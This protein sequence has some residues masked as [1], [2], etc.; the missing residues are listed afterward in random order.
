M[1]APCFSKRAQSASNVRGYVARSFGLLN[2][3][4]FTN[5]LTTVCLQIEAALSTN[6]I[7]P[8]WR[9][10]IVGTKPISSL[11]GRALYAALNSSNVLAIIILCI[12]PLCRCKCR[13]FFHSAYKFISKSGFYLYM[14][15]YGSNKR[16]TLKCAADLLKIQL[17][18]I[19]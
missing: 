18:L 9:A 12:D 19:F 10:P 7:W 3:V 16:I 5:M 8:L 4:G 17:F 1:S 6:E 15:H 13:N 14:F 11:F 2:C